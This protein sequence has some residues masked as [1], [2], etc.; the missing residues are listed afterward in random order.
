MSRWVKV[1]IC[2]GTTPVE[3]ETEEGRQFLSLY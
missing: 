2:E 1:Y 3:I